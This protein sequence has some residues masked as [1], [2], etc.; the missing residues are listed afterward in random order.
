MSLEQHVERVTR[1][2]EAWARRDIDALIE[3]CDPG[4]ELVLS[5]NLV[6]GGSYDGKIVRGREYATRAEA[7]EAVGL[8]G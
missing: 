1:M 4:V 3:F 8:A 7:R 6:E 2:A 5:R